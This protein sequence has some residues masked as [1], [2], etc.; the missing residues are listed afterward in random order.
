MGKVL[1]QADADVRTT[2]LSITPDF[3]FLG[4]AS[5]VDLVKNWFFVNPRL[6][7]AYDMYK[8]WQLYLSAG[9]THREPTKVDILG[10]WG[11]YDSA[12]YVRLKQGID[13]LSEQ[14]LDMEVV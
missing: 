8:S 11:L 12:Q 2:R 5:D 14:V 9:S 13:F 4:M 3:N 1:F 7:V 6:G 10:G